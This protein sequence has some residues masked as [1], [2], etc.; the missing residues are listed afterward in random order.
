MM[1]ARLPKITRLEEKPV[2]SA[3][4]AEMIEVST[5]RVSI[6]QSSAVL[7]SY[8]NVMT[9][10]SVIDLDKNGVPDVVFVSTA[11]TGGGLVEVGVLRALAGNTGSELFTVN[12]PALRVNA[13]SSVAT[14]D[15]DGD[16]KVDPDEPRFATTV[17]SGS[18]NTT[19]FGSD[20][21]GRAHV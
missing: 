2:P 1:P 9:T 10:P 21:I 7:P 19:T 12:D 17:T 5:P 3:I 20:E 11:S 6:I 18:I 16:G 14:G 13:T 4:A 15:V 8:L